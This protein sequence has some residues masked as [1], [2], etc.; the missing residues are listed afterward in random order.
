[1]L[2]QNLT[3]VA[4]LG[5]TVGSSFTQLGSTITQSMGTANKSVKELTQEQKKLSTHIKQSKLAGADVSLL[6]RQYQTLGQQI[7]QATKRAQSSGQGQ[8]IGAGFKRATQLGSTAIGSIWNTATALGGLITHTNQQTAA[9]A[10]LAHAQGMNVSQFQAWNGVAKQAG[11]FGANISTMMTKLSHKYAEFQ[12]QGTKSP[13]AAAFGKLDISPKMMAGMHAAQQFEVVMKRLQKV[14][15]QQQA[16]DLAK[17][18]LGSGGDQVIGYIRSTHKGLDNLLQTQSKFNLLTHQGAS[19]ATRYNHAFKNLRTVVSS[20]WQEISGIVGGAMSGSLNQLN[21]LLVNFVKNNKTQLVSFFKSLAQGA[22][23]TVSA[24]LTLGQGI[25]RVVQ[26]MGGWQT[27]GLAMA[28][29]L[30]GRLVAGLF[31]FRTVLQGAMTSIREAQ[32]VMAAFNLV[33]QANPIGVVTAVVGGLVFAGVELYRHWDTVVGWFHGALDWFKS[34]FPKTFGVIKAVLSWS[35][36]ATI[37]SAWGVITGYF[38]GLWTNISS[39]FTHFWAG[40]K[41]LFG[42]TPLGLVLNNWES[43]SDYFSGLWANVTALFKAG[44]GAVKSLF[45]W[46]PIAT[47]QS[48]WGAITGYFNEL[49]TNISSVFTHFWA[50]V[51]TLFGWTPLGLVLNNWG[52]LS[53]YF[54]GLWANVTALFKAGWGAVK[55]L[56]SWAPLAEVKASFQPLTLYFEK[57]WNKITGIFKKG[58]GWVKGKLGK[59]KSW[60]GKLAFWKSKDSAQQKPEPPKTPKAEPSKIGKTMRRVARVN[61]A[62]M[63]GTLV[64]AAAATAAVNPPNSTGMSQGA[65]RTKAAL[66]HVYQGSQTSHVRQVNVGGITVVAAP[67]QSPAQVGDAVYSRFAEADGAALYDFPEA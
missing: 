26:F 49:W 48:T 4:S 67:G 31:S 39:E 23:L 42:W 65:Q 55:S 56:L 32:G 43:L 15:S 66:Q 21:G 1:M 18:L 9:I 5:A 14:K 17:M 61:A 54:S 37:Q 34:A 60:V 52:A 41:T 64:G 58:F 3:T 57:L 8:E 36:I 10:K 51:K 19:G 11:V 59:I 25:N 16:G 50:G 33:M 28:S 62:V 47:I 35:P 13:M 46:S 27:V 6:A 12:A 45:S 40:I 38:S 44:W 29:L 20:G 24:L 22:Q 7:E 53:D 63:A 2:T 30:T